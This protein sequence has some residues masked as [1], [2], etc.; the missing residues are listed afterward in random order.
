[1]LKLTSSHHSDCFYVSTN[2]DPLTRYT[3]PSPRKPLTHW[4]CSARNSRH[5]A[6]S[7]G[8]NQNLREFRV[9]EARI[10]VPHMLQG[11]QNIIK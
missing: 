1:M 9:L 11:S 8:I 6:L 7:P 10:F 5:S 3:V 4:T 2:T